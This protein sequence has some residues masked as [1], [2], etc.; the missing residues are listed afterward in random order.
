[1]LNKE[2]LKPPRTSP[3]RKI[4]FQPSRIGS[5]RYVVSEG[6]HF[7]TR[8]K[9]VM[10]KVLAINAFPLFHLPVRTKEQILSKINLSI[11]SLKQKGNERK[12]GESYHFEEMQKIISKNGL[13]NE[14]MM[15]IA[16]K[17]GETLSEPYAKSLIELRN[18]GYKILKMEIASMN[19]SDPFSGVEMGVDDTPKRS[20]ERA[21]VFNRAE[22]TISLK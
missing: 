18:Q 8:Q 2:F 15:G 10:R 20:Q 17:Y 16:S 7:I 13:T 22:R 14:I 6:N 3:H 4:A 19:L 12:P 9:R 21:I 5:D 11:E 1:V